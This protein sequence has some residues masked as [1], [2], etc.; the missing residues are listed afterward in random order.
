MQEIQFKSKVFSVS[1]SIGKGKDLTIDPKVEIILSM[2]H[3][4]LKS[5]HPFKIDSE[6]KLSPK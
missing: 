2:L 5:I 6:T 1:Q 3:E 4:S